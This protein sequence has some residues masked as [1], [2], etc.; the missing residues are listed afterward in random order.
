MAPQQSNA[1]AA[2]AEF[3]SASAALLLITVHFKINAR[4]AL[5]YVR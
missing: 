3:D 4:S 1:F 2:G 5:R